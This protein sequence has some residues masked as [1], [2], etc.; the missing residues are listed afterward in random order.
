MCN[1]CFCHA[2][3]LFLDS[4][5]LH[6]SSTQNTIPGVFYLN[7]FKPL[8]YSCALKVLAKYGG[9]SDRCEIT[10]LSYIDDKYGD[11]ISIKRDVFQIKRQY[12]L[13][14]GRYDF[15]LHVSTVFCISYF[16]KLTKNLYPDNN[17]C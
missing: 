14:I 5:C 1:Y 16:R 17:C 11:V 8:L 4:T 13:S 6:I 9:S 15:C 2:Y 12:D 7:Y 3:F 10:Q